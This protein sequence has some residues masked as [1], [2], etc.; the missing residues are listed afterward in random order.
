MQF[1]REERSALISLAAGEELAARK[2]HLFA[3]LLTDGSLAE[4]MAHLAAEHISRHAAILSL[5]EGE[6]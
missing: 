4:E 1:E 5:A 3:G 2:A 6:T